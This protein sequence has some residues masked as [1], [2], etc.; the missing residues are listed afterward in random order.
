MR[1]G[2]QGSEWW[3]CSRGREGI[4]AAAH[5]GKGE[6]MQHSVDRSHSHL[7]KLLSLLDA[8]LVERV[9]KVKHVSDVLI[10][11]CLIPNRFTVSAAQPRQLTARQTEQ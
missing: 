11:L 8:G 1:G 5:Q 10:F 3:Y 2:L 7:S 9:I 4:T 6:V